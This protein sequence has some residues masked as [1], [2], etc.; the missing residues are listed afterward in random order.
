MKHKFLL[1]KDR[2]LDAFLA[3]SIKNVQL[4]HLRNLDA[5]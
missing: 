4:Y 2:E 3:K 1:F 5:C